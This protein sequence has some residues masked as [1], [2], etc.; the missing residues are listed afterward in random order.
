MRFFMYKGIPWPSSEC[1][2]SFQVSGML[3]FFFIVKT[4][5][6][7]LQVERVMENLGAKD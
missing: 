1:Q 5:N 7:I 3:F 4:Y 6:G 2:A